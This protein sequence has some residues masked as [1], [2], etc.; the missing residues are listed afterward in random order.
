[1][2][3][4]LE[5]TFGVAIVEFDYGNHFH[6]QGV[7]LI[8]TMSLAIVLWFMS[9]LL[10]AKPIIK[11]IVEPFVRRRA[12]EAS[13]VLLRTKTRSEATSEM[14]RRGAKRRVLL[15]PRRFARVFLVLFLRFVA[16]LLACS[17]NVLISLL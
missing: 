1:M 13:Y 3:L 17:L 7:Q 5:G 12:I 11:F 14:L 15:P 8:V 4:M 6:R 16:M 9:A 2:S 10:F